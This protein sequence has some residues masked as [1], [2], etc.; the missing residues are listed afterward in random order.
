MPEGHVPEVSD[1]DLPRA[2]HVASRLLEV[3][4]MRPA[5]ARR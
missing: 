2:S 5:S 3:A 4:R 1:T